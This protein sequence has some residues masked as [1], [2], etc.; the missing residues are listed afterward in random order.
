MAN[1]KAELRFR[2]TQ[3]VTNLHT[4]GWSLQAR[5]GS[6]SAVLRHLSLVPPRGASPAGR[7]NLQLPV[8]PKLVVFGAVE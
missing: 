4:T 5:R 6:S 1:R 3:S 8:C 7:A 2:E